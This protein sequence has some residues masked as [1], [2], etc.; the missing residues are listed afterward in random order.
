[1][2]SKEASPDNRLP[3]ASPDNRLPGAFGF[4]FSTVPCVVLRFRSMEGVYL[5]SSLAALRQLGSVISEKQELLVLSSSSV[6]SSVTPR[7]RASWLSL[8]QRHFVC[9]L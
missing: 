2:F 8:Q 1:M 4:L 9:Y 5:K 6:G 3:E 7:L